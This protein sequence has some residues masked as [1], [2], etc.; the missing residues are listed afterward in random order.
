MM[1]ALLLARAT[2][3]DAIS[4]EFLDAAR[5]HLT[6]DGADAR[7]ARRRGRDTPPRAAPPGWGVVTTTATRPDRRLHYAWVIAGVTFVV[8]LI[9]AGVRATPGVLMVP[10]EDE[11]GWSRAAISGGGR[12]Q[13]RALRTDRPV[14]RRGDGSLGPAP[15]GAVRARVARR[16][17]GGL[18]ADAAPNGS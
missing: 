14:R 9:T 11:F 10:L 6:S 16:L 18:D 3:G 2:R 5:E 17:G 8:L 15:H 4:D 1:G 13:H 12:R 7:R